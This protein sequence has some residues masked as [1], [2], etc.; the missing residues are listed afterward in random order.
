VFGKSIT[1]PER[2]RTTRLLPVPGLPWRT[3]ALAFLAIVGSVYALVRHYTRPEIAPQGESI[4]ELPAPELEL[5]PADSSQ[6]R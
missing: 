3:F 1:R 4:R 5:A 6:P 2:P